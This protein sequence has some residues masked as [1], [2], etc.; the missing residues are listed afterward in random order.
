MNVAFVRLL[1]LYSLKDMSGSDHD[2][3]KDLSTVKYSIQN[4]ISP[5]NWCQWRPLTVLIPQPSLLDLFACLVNNV[6]V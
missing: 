5:P 3:V 6:S 4:T 2:G 1:V